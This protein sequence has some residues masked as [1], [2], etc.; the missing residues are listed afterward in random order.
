MRLTI[1]HTN[2]LHGHLVPWVGWEGDLKGKT[3]GGLATFSRRDLGR[4]ARARR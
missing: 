2:D 3:I 1:L 4:S